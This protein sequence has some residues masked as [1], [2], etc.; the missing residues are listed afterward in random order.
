MHR[1]T[2]TASVST[3][4][5]VYILGCVSTAVERNR[6]HD[7]FTGVP[8][9]TSTGYGAYFT[10]T[11]A[12]AGTEN[13]AVNNLIYNFTGSGTLYGLG[14]AGSDFVRFYNN[15]ISLDNQTGTGATQTTYGIYQTTI[16]TGI[17]IKNNVISVTR[18]GGSGD[19]AALYYATTTSTI[20][21][22]YNALSVGTGSVY[23]TGKFGSLDFVTLANWRTANTASPYDQNSVDE[24]PAFV[25]AATGNLRPT[26][27][28]LN[29]TATPL[30]RVPAD[31]SGTARS[32]T[33]P[34]MGAFEFT[35]A[36]DDVALLS[37]DA[38]TG[39][40][41][42]GAQTVTVTIRNNGSA[43]LNTVRL[44]YTVNGGT[45]VGQTFALTGGLAAGLTR[46]VSF[47]VPAT[48]V[49]GATTLTVTAS[50]PNGNVDANASNNTLTKTVYTALAGTYTID[51]TQPTGGTNFASFTAA[52]A[53]LN[54]GGISA[55]VR[56]NVLNGPYTEQFSLGVIPGVSATDTVLV[57]GGTARQTLS[58]AGTAGQ[59]AAVLLN[60]TDYVTLRNLTI[61]VSAGVTYGIGVHLVG[62]ANNN[63]VSGCVV[64]APATATSSTANAGIAAS[65]SLTSASTAGDANNFRVENNVISGGYYGIILTGTSTT[66]RTTGIR[67]T[68]NE[69]RDFYTYGIDV[70]NTSGARILANDVHRTTRP[71]V[72]TFYGVYLVGSVGTAVERNR[73]HDS[74]TGA[75]A[76]TGTGYGLYATTSDG[77]AGTE[78]DF[79]NNL[80][81]H[82]NG[83]GTEYGI[84]NSG[85][86]FAR[87]Y[88]NTIALD[89]P[90]AA[91]ATLSYG[92]YQTTLATGIDFRNNLVSV[93]R[94]GTA[95]RFA[96]F[97][98]TPTSTIGS[99]YNDLF[100]GTGSN[101]FTGHV[102]PS[103]TVT[104][105]YAT[106]ASWRAANPTYDQNSVQAAPQFVNVATGNLQPTAVQ[107]NGA[108]TPLARVPRDFANVLRTS[109]PDIGAYEF[110]PSSDDVAVVSIDAPTSPASP[111]ATPVTVTIRNGGSSPLTSVT[112]SYSLNG[113]TPVVQNFTGLA[114]APAATQQ[115]TFTQG[116]VAP[117][118]SNTLS[119][120]GSLP[121]GNADGNA[122]NNTQTI[123]FLQ[124]T[125]ANDEPCTAVA[126]GTSP[127]SSSNSGAT[128]SIQNGI[129][130]PTCAGGALPRDVWFAFT[131]SGTSTTLTLTGNPAG[132]VRVFSSADCAA[133]PFTQVFC[134]GSGTNNT[135]LG[136][137]LVPGLTAGQRYYVAVSGFGSSDT[138]G[139]FT[140]AATALLGTRSTNS[141]ALA[142][143]PNPS[144]TGQLTLRL[145]PGRAG[146]GT[147]E[148]LNAL[149]QCVKRQPLAGTGEQQV[150]TT[151]LAAGLYT[152]RVQAGS[153]VLTRK[154]VLQ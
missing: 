116:V 1:T 126:L 32:A 18:A 140:I 53:A 59:P 98:L 2:R 95:K 8:T 63:R 34:D 114:L 120:T 25:S 61:D 121:N 51:K 5:G 89:N 30:A 123:T 77:A 48:V 79:V 47:T 138:A 83:A 81:Y 54:G 20:A 117:S 11:D 112:L 96:L 26:A 128:T 60:G 14:S 28:S 135:T 82:F 106:L 17:D 129:N 73:I 78:N 7:P 144:A 4:Y 97:F 136:T 38:P 145:A 122:G 55:P 152:L 62:Q 45:A 100:V 103:S 134:L 154:V 68:G 42:P 52:A 13:D 115:L 64:L 65:G 118:G 29:G 88:H 93:T 92:F 43:L 111:S 90:N 72:S 127:V 44:D 119:V 101:Y 131:P 67:V 87:Y 39:P 139:A 125:P 91:G 102:G 108:G 130:T 74:F 50:L 23:F 21:S 76:D 143:Y 133:G 124:P 147:V 36:A 31:F 35:P 9:S 105:D 66:A 137:V 22:N 149:G 49:V 58:Y 86:D 16:A 104:Q 3:F 33:A 69:V 148:L 84:Y 113:G 19:K 40:A 107:L 27:V 80:V 75:P 99:D 56:L 15:T 146:T 24:G 109:P 151:G 142:V 6:I 37:I 70:E 110:S 12:T 57:D 41:T 150:L 141:A 46:A 10:T 94:A 153:E 71:D 85:S 132:T